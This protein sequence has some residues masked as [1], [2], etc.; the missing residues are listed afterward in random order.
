MSPR[1][2]ELQHLVEIA[3]LQIF[4][5]TVRVMPRRMALAVGASFG[6][7]AWALRIRRDVVLANLTQ[8]FPEETKTR[9]IE[10]GRQAVA[11]FGRTCVEYLRQSGHDRAQVHQLARLDG[12]EALRK[13]IASGGGVLMVTAHLGSWAM[14]LGVLEA[15]GIPTALLVGQQKNP[16][17]DRLI[18]GIPGASVPF[19]KKGGRAPRQ[20]LECPREGR[21]VIMV[22]DHYISSEALWAP[23]LGRQASTLPLP[24]ALIAK[25][26]RPL[27]MMAGCRGA[28]GLHHVTVREIPVPAQ[29]EGD[30][31]K[32]EVATL[33]NRE[34]G[35]EILAHPEHYWWYHK[36]W[37]VR[38]IYKKRTHVI[39]QPP[40]SGPEAESA[41]GGGCRRSRSRS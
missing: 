1:L 33:I 24:G 23:F 12:L 25:Y 31:L 38:G 15:E 2:V 26:R 30:E 18:L 4:S 29:L 13:A 20:I 3:A 37:K 8:A 14:Y 6:R 36:R 10:I 35:Q 40:E 17:V 21:V 32:L 5:R 11:N 19:I 34:L 41:G 39:G 27:F 7:V 16:H 9:R 22:A 28:D